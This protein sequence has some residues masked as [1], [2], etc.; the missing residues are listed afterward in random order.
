MNTS[1]QPSSD[2]T[3]TARALE[4]TIH[5]GLVVLLLLW[6]FR[7]SQPFIDVIV[8]SI[9]I[10]V[11]VHPIFERLKH[12]LGG[13]NRLSAILI[14]LL[15]FIILFVPACM[16]AGSLV[17][18]VQKYSADIDARNLSVPPPLESI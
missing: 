14:T 10:A 17:D 8:W 15:A 12:V 1:D 3:V 11:A 18:T 6:C 7:I 4:A 16:L 13:R 2:K 9:I 5:I